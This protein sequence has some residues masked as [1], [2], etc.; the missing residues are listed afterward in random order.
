MAPQS[1][2]IYYLKRTMLLVMSLAYASWKL[3]TI[4]HRPFLI[5]AETM[6]QITDNSR[7]LLLFLARQND[8]NSSYGS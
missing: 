3:H 1:D 8:C 4:G 6:R 7:R 5:A 2:I